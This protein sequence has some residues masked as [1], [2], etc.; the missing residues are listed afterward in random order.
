MQ[1]HDGLKFTVGIG[2]KETAD[3]SG[4]VCIHKVAIAVA[5]SVILLI[6]V[7]F[8]VALALICQR[9]RM[10]RKPHFKASLD[11]SSSSSHSAGSTRTISN[12]IPFGIGVF[13]TEKC[14]GVYSFSSVSD[15]GTD[16]ATVTPST[17]HL[18]PDLDMIPRPPP[19]KQDDPL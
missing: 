10:Q 19:P 2:V 17:S 18:P 16:E 7:V 1:W 13:R 6:Q 11:I 8:V 3:L 4:I 5:S 15:A 14:D 9:Y 12:P